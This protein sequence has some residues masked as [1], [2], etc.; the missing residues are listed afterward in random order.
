MRMRES[1]D[2]WIR[3]AV[4]VL[5]LPIGLIAYS[6]RAVLLALLGAPRRRIDR[7]YTGFARVCLRFG[8]TELVVRG[9][10]NLKPDQAYVIVPN[11]ESN[12]DAPGLLV[13]LE[14]ISVRF[15]VK[16]QIMRIPIFGH[17][18]RATGNVRVD[19]HNTKRDA[20][21]IREGMAERAMDVSVL[22][23]AE[24]TRSRDGAFHTFKKG[25][26][27]T[28]IHSGLP[29]LPI[30]HAG[31]HRIWTPLSLWIRKLPMVVE[32]GEPIPVEGLDTDDRDRLCE[33]THKTVTS[34][35]LAAR[36][37]LREMGHDPGGID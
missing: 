21:A 14:Q 9:R 27:V 35:R 23:Y 32:I 4:C 11:H 18:L 5:V 20:E 19:R 37:R 28:A 3:T 26:F 16:R 34:L 8:G 17:A 15:I 10:E 22:F 12:W 29:V 13:A 7:C 31:S 33:Q 24:G 6:T 30:G 36:K 1:L 2:T 25:A